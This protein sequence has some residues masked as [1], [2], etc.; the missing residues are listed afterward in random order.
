[1]SEDIE[2]RPYRDGDEEGIVE[3][4]QL[5]FP[6]WA[7]RENALQTWKWKFVNNPLNIMVPVALKRGKVIGVTPNSLMNFKLGASVVKADYGGDS[8]VHPDYRGLGIYTK[9]EFIKEKMRLEHNIQFSYFS[10][11]HPAVIKDAIKRNRTQFPFTINVMVK[12]RDVKQHLKMRPMKN[13]TI[14]RYGYSTLKI[15]NGV[16]NALTPA[17][18]HADDFSIEEVSH[19]DNRINVF[20]EKIK[21]KY[22]FIIERRSEYLNWKY[23][24]F[25]TIKYKVKQAVK[26]GEVLGY[27]VIELR[28]D[29]PYVEG[30]IVDMLVYPDR[31]DVSDALFQ[32]ACGY[33]D[34]R[35]VNTVYYRVVKGHPYQE[36]SSRYGFVNAQSINKIH[37]F[38]KVMAMEK[39]FE[40]LRHASPERVYYSYSETL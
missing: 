3:L 34:D 5:S 8:A 4:L 21:D 19:F 17:Q 38:C 31:R 28:A 32:D 36:L 33:F 35:G 39:E 30:Y 15:L 7:K 26:D 16:R 23:C 37:V 9:L 27:I 24:D 1:M 29:D 25:P 6:F 10:T 12:I 22:D 11:S 14:I 18:K 20:W 2:M 13:P 40:V